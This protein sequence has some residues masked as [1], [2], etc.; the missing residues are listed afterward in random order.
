[1]GALSNVIS[2]I[3]SFK[4]YVLLPIIIFL[5]SLIFRLEV[6]KSIQAVLT[7]GIGFIGIFI[8][9][10][11]F[12]KSTGPAVQAVVE[13]SGLHSNALDVGWPPLVAITWSFKLAPVFMVLVMIINIIMLLCKLTNTVN[14][15]IWNSFCCSNWIAFNTCCI[16]VGVYTS[17]N[18]IHS[19]WRPC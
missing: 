9:F 11:Y 12:V 16:I 15:D 3:L 7:I 6:K 5:F 10:E 17:R 14:I 4:A 1:M 18:K 2:Y 19:P 8:I 13:R